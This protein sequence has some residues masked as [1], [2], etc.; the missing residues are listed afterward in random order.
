[1]LHE[2]QRNGYVQRER[3]MFSLPPACLLYSLLLIELT[4]LEMSDPEQHHWTWKL[5]VGY[6]ICFTNIFE[7]NALDFCIVKPGWY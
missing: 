5:L 1:M 2:H 3:D 4:L 7:D 6:I